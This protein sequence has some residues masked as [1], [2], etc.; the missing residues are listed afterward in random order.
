MYKAIM[1]AAFS[2]KRAPQR[3][4][5]DPARWGFYRIWAY[6]RRTVDL[7]SPSACAI[8]PARPIRPTIGGFLLRLARNPGLSPASPSSSNR[9]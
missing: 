9:Y 7:L 3:P 4:S 5:F 6:T 1:S 2:S 8:F